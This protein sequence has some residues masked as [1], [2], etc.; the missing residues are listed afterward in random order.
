M[1]NT[2]EDKPSTNAA[3]DEILSEE[4]LDNVAGGMGIGIALLLFKAV[5]SLVN[6]RTTPDIKN[7]TFLNETDFD[8]VQNYGGTGAGGD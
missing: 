7:G 1:D 2:R 3:A 4:E 5:N 8:T 6:S